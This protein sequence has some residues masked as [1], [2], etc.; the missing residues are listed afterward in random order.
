M[1]NALR[2]GN[3]AQWYQQTLTLRRCMERAGVDALERQRMIKA[4]LAQSSSAK[5]NA[6]VAGYIASWVKE[7]PE[8][9]KEFT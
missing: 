2:V 5:A 8:D 3:R 9:G 6:C 7:H 1:R 4:V